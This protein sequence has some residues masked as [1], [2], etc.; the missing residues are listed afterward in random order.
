MINREVLK[1][2]VINLTGNAIDAMPDGG[3]L[4]V[5]GKVKDNNIVLEFSD[6]G[7]GIPE[8]DRE[9][10]FNPFFTTKT[11]GKGTGLGLYIVYS[12]VKRYGGEISVESETGRGS[13]FTVSLPLLNGDENE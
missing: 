3:V 8:K 11:R 12:D 5:R 1:H 7:T 6:T 9:S 13:V 2:I 10:I 4:S